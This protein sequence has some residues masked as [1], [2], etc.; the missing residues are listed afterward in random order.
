LKKL[1]I[2]LLTVAL[3]L[4]LFAVASAATVNVYMGGRY[5]IEYRS[6]A[7]TL[8]P[9]GKTLIF[10]NLSPSTSNDSMVL[11]NW[12]VKAESGNSWAQLKWEEQTWTVPASASCF[13]Y[14][15][16]QNNIGDMF[17]WQYNTGGPATTIGFQSALNSGGDWGSNGIDTPGQYDPMWFNRPKHVLAFGIHGDSFKVNLEYGPNMMNKDGKDANPMVGTFV[18]KFDAGDVHVGYSTFSDICAGNSFI[19]GTKFK[20]EGLGTLLA[21]YYSSKPYW[22]TASADTFQANISLDEMKLNATL[23]YFIDPN[24]SGD[25]GDNYIGIG[26]GYSGFEKVSV[27]LKYFM[28][29]A[30]GGKHGYDLNATYNVGA[31]NVRA[32]YAVRGSADG[33]IYVGAFGS[34]W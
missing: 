14:A 21:D 9:T 7:S 2:V 23:A 16:G 1:L 25:T 13:T 28:D 26:V 19:V 24:F 20:F 22:A 33:Y 10:E 12:A 18:F 3:T 32:G 17:D 30:N 5:W 27:G 11:I 4:S 31:F 15:F 29:D 34:M 6:N 8:D